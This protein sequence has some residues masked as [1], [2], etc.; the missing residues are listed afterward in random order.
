MKKWLCALLAAALLLALC[1]CGQETTPRNS[2]TATAAKDIET[3]DGAF[4]LHTPGNWAPFEAEP[5]DYLI[6][7]IS[8]DNMG[9]ADIFYYS[10]DIGDITIDDFLSQNKD[11]YSGKIVGDVQSLE[12]PF[13]GYF[14]EYSMVDKGSDDKDYNFHGYEYLYDAAGGILEIDIYYSQTQL[15]SKLFKITDKEL[16]VLRDIAASAGA[17]TKAQ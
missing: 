5:Q 11:Y 17:K 6:L 2:A 15:D 8:D 10:Y 14:F 16:G 7:S 1:A 3:T 12:Q 13:P 4:V 9:H